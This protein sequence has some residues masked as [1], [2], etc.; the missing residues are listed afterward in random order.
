M[1]RV[2]NREGETVGHAKRIIRVASVSRRNSNGND[3]NQGTDLY[4]T[5][6]GTWV[7]YAWSHWQGARE[8]CTAIGIEDAARLAVECGGID[9]DVEH[10]M[11]EGACAALESAIEAL[12]V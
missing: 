11:P 12:E 1:I 2:I 3:I 5:P 8:T 7:A 6:K 9:D 4:V 10:M